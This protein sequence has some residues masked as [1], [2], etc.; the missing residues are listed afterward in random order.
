MSNDVRTTRF[1][2]QRLKDVRVRL[3][4]KSSSEIRMSLDKS[5][6]TNHKLRSAAQNECR[7][8]KN[9]VPSS[10]KIIV[11]PPS[12][13]HGEKDREPAGKDCIQRWA[14]RWALGCVNPASWPY[15]AAGV[16]SRNPGPTL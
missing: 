7:V 12:S 10:L 13:S 9:N 11:P 16:S 5:A 6:L 1:P 14:I 15:L 4:H 3:S 8:A 2:A